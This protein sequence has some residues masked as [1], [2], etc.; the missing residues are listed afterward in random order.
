M[1]RDQLCKEPREKNFQE[2]MKR[3]KDLGRKVLMCLLGTGAG[4]A[5][6]AGWW[7]GCEVQERD[8]GAALLGTHRPWY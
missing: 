1:G 8:M 6:C 5:E 7:K 2:G 3:A 4:V